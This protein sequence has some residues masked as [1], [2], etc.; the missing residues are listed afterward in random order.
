MRLDL[1]LLCLTYVLSQ[2]FRSF[3]AVLAQVL[4]S[5]I[6]ATAD[7]LAYAS[8]LWFIAF[9]AMQI[10]VGAALD[11]IGPRR[12]ASVL[13][14]AGAGGGAL[15]FALATTPTHINIAMTLIGIGCSPI[16]M[17]GYFIFARRFSPARFATL[18]ALMLGVGSIGNLLASYPMAWASEVLGWR[19]ILLLLAVLCALLAGGLFVLIQDPPKATHVQRG[20]TLD[21]LRIR[22]LWPILP[23]LLVSYAPSAAIRGLWM[24]PYLHHVF[25][26]SAYEV[27]MGSLIMGLAMVC[28]TFAYGPLDRLLRTRKWVVLVGN[29]CGVLCCLMLALAVDDS[30]L[31]AVGLLAAIGFFGA[32]FPVIVAHGRSFLPPHLTGRGVTWLNLFAIGGAG[33]L[34]FGSAPMHIMAQTQGGSASAYGI[35]F[36]AFGMILLLGCVFYLYSRDSLH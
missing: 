9:A 21:V 17:S 26:W 30:A 3:L 22:A 29:L 19:S 13:L 28:G 10:P 4:H 15:L 1:L 20:S 23:L 32:S 2:F 34:Q 27:G 5:D 35:L 33:L 25:G 12:T 18:A 11:R 8:G 7:A 6:G 24:G 36:A 31:L 14:L 16:L